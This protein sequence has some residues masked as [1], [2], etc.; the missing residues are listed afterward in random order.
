MLANFAFSKNLIISL[1]IDAGCIPFDFVFEV[2]D[3]FTKMFRIISNIVFSEKNQILNFE[4]ITLKFRVY[5]PKLFNN[6]TFTG[7]ISFSDIPDYVR[8]LIKS[9]FGFN[10]NDNLTFY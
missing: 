5:L 6:D 7:K 8:I 1:N 2:Y 9:I 10:V 3:F 4:P